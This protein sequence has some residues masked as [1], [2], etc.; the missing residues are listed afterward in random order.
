[1]DP[2]TGSV[3][4]WW[5][6]WIALALLST[7]LV[8]AMLLPA[9]S[10]E[11]E[12]GA[13]L[14]LLPLVVA[15]W[16]MTVFYNARQ[17]QAVG[18]DLIDGF[19]VALLVWISVA[20]MMVSGEGDLRA[21]VN[22]L[23]WWISAGLLWMASRRWMAIDDLRQRVIALI[24]GLVCLQA[25]LT[26]HQ[27]LISLPADRI[28]F[29]ANPEEHLRRHNIDA[30]P[31]SAQRELVISR[32]YEG[33]PTGTFAL[34]N[35]L[36]G[37]LLLGIV[38]GGGVISSLV[39]RRGDVK[40]AKRSSPVALGL[41][42]MLLSFAVVLIVICL[43]WTGSR[44]AIVAAAVSC[45]LGVLGAWLLPRLS[46]RLT[47]VGGGLMVLSLVVVTI[48]LAV[49]PSVWSV[50]P[51][52]LQFRFQ[53]W[54]ATLAMLADAPL[55]GAGPGNF[56]DRYLAYRLDEASEGIADPHNWFMETLASAGLPAGVLLLSVIF[57]SLWSMRKTTATNRRAG[58]NWLTAATTTGIVIA[59]MIAVRSWLQQQSIPD[60]DGLIA[61][62]LL[63][64]TVGVASWLVLRGGDVNG[65]EAPQR[66]T[67]WIVAAVFGLLLH[68]T[69]AGGWTVPGMAATWIVLAGALV[70][71]GTEVDRPGKMIGGWPAIVVVGLIAVGSWWWTAWQPVSVSKQ[72]QQLATT[73]FAN[74]RLDLAAQDFAAAAEGDAWDF[75]PWIRV[76]EVRHWELMR[77]PAT[78]QRHE[79]WLAALDEAEQ[80]N[81]RSP[82]IS[83]AKAKQTLIL[84]QRYGRKEDLQ[85]ARE[86]LQRAIELSPSE[87]RNV[88]QAALVERA[89]G[90]DSV[91][92]QLWQRAE[93]LSLA[94]G[95]QVR[96]LDK[97]WVL[98]VRVIGEEV[99]HQGGRGAS[100]KAEW[101]SGESG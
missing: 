38:L 58:T 13:A 57:L 94:G 43:Y 83:T 20:T 84:Y 61:G 29:E 86:S 17:K 87:A 41:T 91:A 52:T 82:L 49:L 27:Q 51:R 8:V 16:G 77:G 63:G 74:G 35:S 42:M 4:P 100:A 31:G 92:D 78:K 7:I 39:Q 68:W 99:V 79:A 76:A 33:G 26:A 70:S 47:A 12:E 36:A 62:S 80:R 15:C 97:T 66:D 37:V 46:T 19:V 40:S 69:V 56:Q 32:L 90:E 75:R 71:V 72:Y 89:L 98:S 73:N 81:S 24:I 2:K 59:V 22:E 25:A 30:P 95:H 9:D 34:A 50:F 53:Y 10:V 11:V 18:F 64:I 48:G 54:K 44:S 65:G 93:E 21:A 67:P 23:W 6:R 1:M 45:L 3:G 88:A 28:R 14:F 96:S 55:T 5:A 85:L 60:P 101:L